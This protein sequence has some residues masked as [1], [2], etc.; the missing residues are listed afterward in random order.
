VQN[1]S[2][3][4]RRL[5]VGTVMLVLIALPLALAFY[6]SRLSAG[7]PPTPTPYPPPTVEGL[8]RIEGT[9]IDENQKP[10]EGVCLAIGPVGCQPVSPRSDK[11]GK[12]YF[13]LPVANVDYDFH[14]TKP[15]YQNL[16]VHA[17]PTGPS[18]FNY[19]L[20]KG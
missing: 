8:W 6:G 10:I 20:K 16:D 9:V 4:D 3:R 12:F 13:D 19:V 2:W 11:N 18:L 7:P 1:L 15:G 5:W 14:F 17:H